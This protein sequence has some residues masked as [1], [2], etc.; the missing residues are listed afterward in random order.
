MKKILLFLSALTIGY[1]LMGQVKPVTGDGNT[2]VLDHFD[3]ASTGETVGTMGYTDGVNG[4]NKAADFS[5]AGNFVIYSSNVNMTNA[6]TVE[7]WVYL[8]SYSK[9]LLNINWSKAYS[10]PSSGHVFHLGIDAQGKITLGGWGF[11]VNNNFISNTPVPTKAWTH[12][13]VSWGDSTKIYINGKKDVASVLP[14]RPAI[15]MSVNYMYLP[16]WGANPGYI[17][18][19]HVSKVQRT[20]GE[21]AS[22]VAGGDPGTVTTMNIN[23]VIPA[24]GGTATGD[25]GVSTYSVGQLVH[26]LNTGSNG[27]VAGGIQQPYDISVQT[28]MENR[29]ITLQ[30]SVYPNPAT[31][32]LKLNIENTDF[33]ELGYK[34]YD[35]NGRILEIRE[36]KER[37]TTIP[38]GSYS[39]SYFILKVF[40]S[41]S[42]IKSFKIIKN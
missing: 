21:I 36:I 2:L 5:S 18:E 26:T 37:E 41:G 8:N 34:L 24:A 15:S 39:S 3:S 29:N 38:M 6:G 31:D 42:E 32:F 4:L 11:S 17:D 20:D 9:G 30:C 10:S 13:A 35:I 40:Q 16:Y 7:M 22:R 14:F 25:N 28:G 27:S 33:G 1:P 12:I 19:L 23:R